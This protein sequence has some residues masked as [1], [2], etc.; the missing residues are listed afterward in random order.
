MQSQDSETLASSG[1][2]IG[3][4]QCEQGPGPGA[5][6]LSGPRGSWRPETT[7]GP[8]RAIQ[9]G[10]PR[11][12][13]P[14]QVPHP[15][16]HKRWSQSRSLRCSVSQSVSRMVD[17][18]GPWTPGPGFLGLGPLA[19]W[20]LGP[21]PQRLLAGSRPWAQDHSTKSRNSP[22]LATSRHRGLILYHALQNPTRSTLSSY[23]GN[24]TVRGSWAPPL[25]QGLFVC[26][27][28]LKRFR[29]TTPMKNARTGLLIPL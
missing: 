10:P 3:P 12:W 19:L 9:G 16:A 25:A 24:V 29:L 23:V 8:R 20:A 27:I 17:E 1:E 13:A 28:A 2:E 18:L 11:P 26:S 14:T 21:E 5:L 4:R 15:N 7:L 6:A 22:N